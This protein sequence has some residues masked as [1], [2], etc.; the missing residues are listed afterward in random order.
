MESNFIPLN[1]FKTEF[2][3]NSSDFFY[4]LFLPRIKSININLPQKTITYF[5]NL[6]EPF[7]NPVNKIHG[8]AIGTIIENLTNSTIYYFTKKQY[9]T[10]DMNI[11]F[12]NSIEI[13]TDFEV[14]IK[15]V[16]SEGMTTFL[17]VE[18]RDKERIL[19]VGSVIKSI[20]SAKF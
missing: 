5:L 17:E 4:S 11:N 19:S 15:C 3:S 9:H 16:K 18:L 14:I 13:N 20:I 1:Q 6:N 2:C 8:G 10:L 12:V 7:I